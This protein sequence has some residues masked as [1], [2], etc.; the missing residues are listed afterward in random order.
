M[1]GQRRD[2]RRGSTGPSPMT[3]LLMYNLYTQIEQLPVKPPVTIVLLFLNI[4]PHFFDVNVLGYEMSSIGENCIYPAKVVTSLVDGHGLSLNRIVLGGFIH[5]DELHLYYNMMSLCWKGINL[6]LKMGSAA[7]LQL[8]VFSLIVSHA[9]LVISAYI[10]YMYTDFTSSYHT[11][12]VG[13]SAVL[14]S[15]KYVWNQTASE[16]THIMGFAVPTKYA[17]WL[18]LVLVSLMHSNVSFLGHLSGILAGVIY[19]HGGQLLKQ[20]HWETAIGGQQ[21]N[22]SNSSGRRSG[23]RSH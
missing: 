1:F 20:L 5:V 16:N 14:F 13:F 12:A 2:T 6:E 3:M 7:F 17:A 18:E 4:W 23:Y 8:I 19:V 15:L 22:F 21:Y 10:L 11:C 9:L